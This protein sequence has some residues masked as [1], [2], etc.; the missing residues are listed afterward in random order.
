LQPRHSSASHPPSPLVL[1]TVD[2]PT[3]MCRTRSGLSNT[4]AVVRQALLCRQI[5]YPTR[6]NHDGFRATTCLRADTHRQARRRHGDLFTPLPVLR[7][8]VATIADGPGLMEI[9]SALTPMEF[10]TQTPESTS[11]P[12]TQRSRDAAVGGPGSAPA[13]RRTRQRHTAACSRGQRP[14]THRR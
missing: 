13:R 9:R 14:A 12:E 6:P 10:R 11:R 8:T 2:S 5:R 7:H 1:S 4:F 3:Q